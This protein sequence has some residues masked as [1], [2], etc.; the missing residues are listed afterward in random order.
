M[1]GF[2]SGQRGQTVNLLLYA[3]VVRIHLHPFQMKQV[4]NKVRRAGSCSFFFYAQPLAE[5]VCR[6][7]GA[8]GARRVVEKVVPLLDYK[9]AK[10]Y[11]PS[12]EV[13]CGHLVA[14]SAISDLQ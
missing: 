3:S 8:W 6:R 10:V 4:Y 9:Q 13:Q 7:S 2:P 12:S 5:E 14:S 11:L 1:G